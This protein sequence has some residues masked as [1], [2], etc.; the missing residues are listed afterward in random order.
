MSVLRLYQLFRSFVLNSESPI[1]SGRTSAQPLPTID[2]LGDQFKPELR[3]GWL[4]Y[5]RETYPDGPVAAADSM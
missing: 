3:A 5:I 1:T 2:G 4:A